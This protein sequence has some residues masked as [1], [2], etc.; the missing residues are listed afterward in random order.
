M[1]SEQDKEK[2]RKGKILP[3]IARRKL[4][5]SGGSVMVAVPK[6]WLEQHSLSSGDEVLMVANGSLRVLPES[7]ELIEK[8]HKILGEVKLSENED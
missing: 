5:A 8:L 7:K 2:I 3:V 1:V 6:E 4:M